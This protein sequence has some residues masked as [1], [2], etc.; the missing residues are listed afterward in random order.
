M[1]NNEIPYK[2]GITEGHQSV[3]GKLILTMGTLAPLT[4]A[5]R[6]GWLVRGLLEMLNIRKNVSGLVASD[7]IKPL[8]MYTPA[9]K[10]NKKINGLKKKKCSAGATDRGK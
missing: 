7:R 4:A 3:V 5:E 6:G 10:P 1:G 9:Q 8:A 2:W